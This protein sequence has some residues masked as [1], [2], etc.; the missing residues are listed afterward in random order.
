MIIPNLVIL[1]NEF[2]PCMLNIT[3]LK[4]RILIKL[5]FMK[6]AQCARAHIAK[7]NFMLEHTKPIFNN[8]NYFLY[9]TFTSTTPS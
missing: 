2:T 3:I 8:K 6:L 5:S 4:D 9:I 7:K 1:Y